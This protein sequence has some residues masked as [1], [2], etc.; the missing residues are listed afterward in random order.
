MHVAQS[1]CEVF[2]ARLQT[3]GTRNPKMKKQERKEKE[4]KTLLVNMIQSLVKL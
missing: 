2:L 1:E 4:N 3:Y